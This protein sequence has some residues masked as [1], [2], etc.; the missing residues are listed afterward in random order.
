MANTTGDAE[1]DDIAR[2]DIA[3]HYAT[4]RGFVKYGLLFTAHVAVILALLGYFLL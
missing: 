2:D 3:Y 1:L 4:Y